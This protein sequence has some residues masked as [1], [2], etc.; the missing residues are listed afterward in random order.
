MAAAKARAVLC[1]G[2]DASALSRLRLL[3]AE[4][5]LKPSAKGGV[6]PSCTEMLTLDREAE[7]MM[8]AKIWG[9]LLPEGEEGH[10]IS[11]PKP[12]CYR[13]GPGESSCPRATAGHMP[14]QPQGLLLVC[15]EAKLRSSC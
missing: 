4:T 14:A 9:Q 8:G 6:F 1:P 7:R 5:A 2:W 15:R 13:T 12:P 10:G 3:P 11:E